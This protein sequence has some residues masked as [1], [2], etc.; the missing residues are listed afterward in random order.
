MSFRLIGKD[1][2]ITV[3]DLGVFPGGSGNPVDI[4]AFATSISVED[5]VD[6]VEVSGIGDLRK[7]K[8]PV[9]AETNI[10]IELRVTDSGLVLVNDSGQPVIG[11]VVSVTYTPNTGN[12]VTGGS[13]GTV[14]RRGILES[15]TWDGQEAD[16]QKQTIQI[17]CDADS[18]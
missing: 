12:V 9:K 11:N 8:R 14:M 2:G 1:V 3:T 6:I 7:Q 10:K 17:A 4:T 15:C 13:V 16:A 18:I 5:K